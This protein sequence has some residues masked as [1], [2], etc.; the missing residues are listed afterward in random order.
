MEKADN[1][2]A[3]TFED[4]AKVIIAEDE[5]GSV[6]RAHLIV[7]FHVEELLK[8]LAPNSAALPSMQLDYFGQVRLLGV[9]GVPDELVKPLLNLGNLRNSFAHRLDFKL[10]PDRMRA[11]YDCFDAEG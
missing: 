7:E 5:L 6:V 10:T 11:L 9:L 3:P 2:D 4:F 1:G 8:L